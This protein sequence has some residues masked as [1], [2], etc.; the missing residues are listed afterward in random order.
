MPSLVNMVFISKNNYLTIKEQFMVEA[1]ALEY[2][3]HSSSVVTNGEEGKDVQQGR[4]GE[5]MLNNNAKC[6]MNT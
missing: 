2:T 1:K 3:H 6:M 5:R 4:G